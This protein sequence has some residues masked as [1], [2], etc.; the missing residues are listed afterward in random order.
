MREIYL[1]K[2]QLSLLKIPFWYF[3]CHLWRSFAESV[4]QMPPKTDMSCETARTCLLFL[5]SR[6][7]LKHI[8]NNPTLGLNSVLQKAVMISILISV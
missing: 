8:L 1:S 5:Y 2:Y 7:A 6:K 4:L 3:G